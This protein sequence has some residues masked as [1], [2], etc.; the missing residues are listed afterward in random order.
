[1]TS[2]DFSGNPMVKSLSFQCR[3]DPDRGTKIPRALQH[4]Q[5]KKKFKNIKIRNI[6]LRTSKV[7]GWKSTGNRAGT[8]SLEFQVL[9]L[10]PS[11][12]D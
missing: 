3:G 2:Q 10:D 5:K 1:M 12:A 6:K 7:P 4:D 11:C 8:Q 9:F